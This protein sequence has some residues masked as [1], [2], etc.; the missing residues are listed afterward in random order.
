LQIP[1]SFLDDYIRLIQTYVPLVPTELIFNPDETGLSDWEERK[2]KPVIVPSDA[3]QTP[4]HCPIDR[5]ARHHTLLCC[6][7]ASGDAYTPLPIT[8]RPSANRTFEKGVSTGI[9]L[10]L[11][12]RLY[13]YVDADLFRKYIQEVFLPAVATNRRLPG[14][15]NKHAILFCDNC[16]RHCSEEIL[17]ELAENGVLGLTYPP[18]TSHIFQVLDL[19]LFGNLKRCKQYQTRDENEDREVDHIIRIFKA[20]ETVTTSMTVRVCWEKAGLTYQQRDGTLYLVV[21]EGRILTA[22]DFQE[23]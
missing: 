7:F 4:L 21:H 15:K 14:C 3:T 13:S 16:V 12:I 17:K 9:D 2:S 11:K 8:P 6:I 5:G 23:V 20:Y 1:R 19:V 10:K 22:P 18:H